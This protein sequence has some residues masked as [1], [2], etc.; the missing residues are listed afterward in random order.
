M[1][2]L[3]SALEEPLLSKQQQ[4]I[5]REIARIAQLAE[6]LKAIIQYGEKAWP[7]SGK[8]PSPKAVAYTKLCDYL[9]GE[10]DK[11]LMKIRI[12]AQTVTNDSAKPKEH[13]SV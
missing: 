9:R 8:T 3:K 13:P 12:P 10:A 7:A 6:A 2:I 4:A 1:A 11:A 5:I